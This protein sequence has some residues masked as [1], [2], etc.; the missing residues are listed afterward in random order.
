MRALIPALLLMTSGC[1]SD[2]WADASMK[3]PAIDATSS[4][5]GTTSTGSNDDVE[6]TEVVQTVTG[7]TTSTSTSA[8]A[9]SSSTTGEPE[10]TKPT[11]AAFTIE[12]SFLSEAGSAV[13]HLE[14][15]ADVVAVELRV[16]GVLAQTTTP[17]AFAYEFFAT[18][19]A[20]ANGEH[21]FEVRVFNDDGAKAVAHATLTVLAPP[22]GTERCT[23]AEQSGTMSWI[24]SVVYETDALLAAGTIATDDGL[25]AAVWR[26][27]PDT[28]APL[29]GWPRTLNQW[30]AH[31][32]WMAATSQAAALAVD[33]HGYLAVA[34][35]LGAGPLSQPY[36]ALLSPEGSAIWEYL[37]SPG[38]EIAGVATARAPDEHLLAVG[39]RVTS[40]EPISHD[41]IVWSHTPTVN[42]TVVNVLS[43]PL[44]DDEA[45]DETNTLSERLRG[46]ALH[47][48]EDTMVLVGERT[49]RSKV[50]P[51]QR[52]RAFVARFS[53]DGAYLGQW[54]SDGNWTLHDGARA[55][56]VCGDSLVMGGWGREVD[57]VNPLTRFIESDGTAADRRP[58]LIAGTLTR[59]IACDREVKVFSAGTQDLL[60]DSNGRVFAFRD[61][62]S[63][64]AYDIKH[65]GESLDG[66]N[67]AACDERGF[68][69]A[70]G[71]QTTQVK[72]QAFLRVYH[73]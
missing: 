40:L 33:D 14:A 30:T 28:C 62:D 21:D 13:L 1:L 54:T 12:P 25:R 3:F 24:S 37:G 46:I 60:G 42:L 63:P 70:G 29:P 57:E 35:N 10:V 41:A 4:S 43:A 7:A 39:S 73:P 68:C 51:A 5:T 69:A 48:S 45:P 58:E 22:A 36:L 20:M 49:Y 50:L 34:A 8:G 47:P 56:S 16:D 52:E 38:D 44:Q 59:G 65:G 32:E 31:F 11:I 17:D 71:V 72:T 26:L 9:P 2:L 23:F 64:L 53:P 15:S 19:A 18:S 66:F 55:V 27:D 61:A 67:A 6:L